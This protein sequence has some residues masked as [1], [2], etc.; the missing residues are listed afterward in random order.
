MLFLI[1]SYPALSVP[2]IDGKIQTENK[3]FIKKPYKKGTI[4]KIYT[5]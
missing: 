4:D 2:H 1:F 5:F 3:Y